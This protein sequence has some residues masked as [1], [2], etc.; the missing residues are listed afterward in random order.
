MNGNSTRAPMTL[1]LQP[2]SPS[3]AGRDRVAAMALIYRLISS[4]TD[5]VDFARFSRELARLLLDNRG[6]SPAQVAVETCFT[7]IKLPQRTAVPLGLI[8]Q[9]LLCAR[10][11]GPVGETGEVSR[12]SLTLDMAEGGAGTLGVTGRGT[13][14]PMVELNPS[15]AP[16][17]KI[18]EQLAERS[19]G[20]YSAPAGGDC[21]VDRAFRCSP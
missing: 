10:L 16:G 14:N 3:S 19:H 9:E 4:E 11:N 15:T 17:G 12:I 1:A 2:D 13:A 18:L 21:R 20:K 8:L 5:P 7:E 6:I